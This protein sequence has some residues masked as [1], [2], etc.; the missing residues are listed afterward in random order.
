[1][2]D[3]WGIRTPAHSTW[4]SDTVRLLTTL[5]RVEEAQALA[6]EDVARARAVRRPAAARDRAARRGAGAPRI[7]ERFDASRSTVLRPSPARLELALSLLELGAA[8]RRAGHRTDAREPL[9]E[10]VDARRRVRRDRRSPPRPT[11]SS[12]PPARARA[13]TRSRAAAG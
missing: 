5:D 10:A 4:R 8:L 3:A 2:E 7:V 9:R 13:A 11:T 1:M 12:S 6:E